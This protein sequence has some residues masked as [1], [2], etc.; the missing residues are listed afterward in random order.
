M[1]PA[2]SGLAAA[3]F[4]GRTWQA[5]PPDGNVRMSLEMLLAE[6]E[7]YRALVRFARAMDQR[8]GPDDCGCGL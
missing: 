3:A 8:V 5:T 2:Q 4:A 1:R 6:R 7:I